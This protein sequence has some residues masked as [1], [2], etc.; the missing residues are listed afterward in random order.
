MPVGPP[1]W[2]VQTLRTSIARSERHAFVIGRAEATCDQMRLVCRREPRAQE[3]CYL[4]SRC[5][6]EVR[7]EQSRY[8]AGTA[9]MRLWNTPG[10]K[11][12]CSECVA[13]KDYQGC[14]RAR[15]YPRSSS[16]VR[17]GSKTPRPFLAA[18]QLPARADKL[19]EQFLFWKVSAFLL[20]HREEHGPV[21]QLGRR[22]RRSRAGRNARLVGVIANF[23]VRSRVRN[24]TTKLVAL[25]SFLCATR[26]TALDATGIR[27]LHS[28]SPVTRSQTVVAPS[29]YFGVSRSTHF[30]A[31]HNGPVASMAP[32]SRRGAVLELRSGS[33]H[34]TAL[35]SVQPQGAVIGRQRSI[36]PILNAPKNSG[37]Q[38]RFGQ[39]RRR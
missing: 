20:P 31:R 16:P 13:A 23:A 17:L 19:V 36:A 4:F 39:R 27:L 34:A 29:L 24:R 7:S 35:L 5:L 3:H 12:T 2:C 15:I 11:S 22:Q 21:H 8:R 32:I 25:L 30:P 9:P 28:H 1:N 6:T 37:Q 38:E 18:H 26:W 14:V 10:C 33:A